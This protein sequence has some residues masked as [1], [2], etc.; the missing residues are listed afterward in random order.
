LMFADGSVE[1]VPVRADVKL[2]KKQV[3]REVSFRRS[4]A[5]AISVET[6]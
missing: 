1:T 5:M 4:Q 3:G 2:D 6:P